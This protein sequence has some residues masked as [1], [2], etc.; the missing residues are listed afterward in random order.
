MIDFEI[1]VLSDLASGSFLLFGHHIHIILSVDFEVFIASFL[2]GTISIVYYCTLSK[3]TTINWA[4]SLLEWNG[5]K[6]FLANVHQVE[7]LL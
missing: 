3:M 4:N 5:C 2:Y 7:P 6:W 1:K